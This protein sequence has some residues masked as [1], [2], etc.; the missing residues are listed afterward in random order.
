ML[1][2]SFVRG[3]ARKQSI[4]YTVQKRVAVVCLLNGQDLTAKAREDSE[5]NSL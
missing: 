5:R 4:S 2:L 1:Y 3:H